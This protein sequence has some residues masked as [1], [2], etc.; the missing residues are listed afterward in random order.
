MSPLSIVASNFW[1]LPLRYKIPSLNKQFISQIVVIIFNAFTLK[2]FFISFSLHC[3]HTYSHNSPIPPP[4]P[5]SP[6]LPLSRLPLSLV[7]F[8][9]WLPPF[10][11]VCGC[12]C[13][14]LLAILS[15]SPS[16]FLSLS[17]S[18]RWFFSFFSNS[19]PW[20]EI[21]VSCS[22]SC[23]TYNPFLSSISFSFSQFLLPS[24][25]L[26]VIVLVFGRVWWALSYPPST[27]KGQALHHQIM[28]TLR[29][30]EACALPQL[31][32]V[33]NYNHSMPT[34]VHSLLFFV[35]LPLVGSRL[36]SSPTLLCVI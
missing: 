7:M 20:S 10:S 26:P 24:L 28:Q 5:L 3:T 8:M 36:A 35:L 2:I 9:V 16:L 1:T 15:I 23:S 11:C 31:I 17:L 4:V 29:P 21:V 25:F 33:G 27:G 32:I 34:S 6:Y 12:L 13:L 22:F 30:L 14:E 19:L 18:L